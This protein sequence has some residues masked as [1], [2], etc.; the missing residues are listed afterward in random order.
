M[1]GRIIT[2]AILTL[3]FA[4]PVLADEP[5]SPG[6][7]KREHRQKERIKEGVES[8]QLTK[9]EAR[10]LRHEQKRIK[11]KEEVMKSDGTLTKGERK[12]LHQDLNK[13]SEHIAEQKHDA[14]T[15]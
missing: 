9:K 15:R 11:A 8:G 2:I 7:N 1:L 14:Q 5:A 13:A 3:T 6:I 4:L 12:E 10:R